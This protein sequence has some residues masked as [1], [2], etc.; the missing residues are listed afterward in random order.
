MKPFLPGKVYKE[1]SKGLQS[2]YVILAQK[3]PSPYTDIY[4]KT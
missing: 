2:S 3:G 1:K 4:A